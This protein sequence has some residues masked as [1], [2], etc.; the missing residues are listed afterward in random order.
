M[1]V[2]VL[3]TGASGYVGGRLLQLLSAR[4]FP[5]RCLAR[6]P[7]FLSDQITANVDVVRADLL[8]RDSLPWA[9]EGIDSA[10]YLVHSMGSDGDFEEMDRLAARNFAQAAANAGVRRIIYLGGLGDE[11]DRL[12]AHLR[13][14][15]EVGKVLRSTGVQVIEFRASIVLGAGSLSFEM[16]RALVEK[17]PVMITPKWVTVLAQP[18]AVDDLLA[19]LVAA[20]G[21]ITSESRIYEI[22]GADQVS[23]GG[24]M[25]EYARQR[26]LRRLQIPVPV[27]TP[28]LSSLWLGFVTPLYVRTGRKLIESVRHATIVRDQS[29]LVDFKIRPVGY[30]EA[31]AAALRNEN[32]EFAETRGPAAISASEALSNGGSARTSATPAPVFRP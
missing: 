7:E 22:G 18:I 24:L 17:L 1:E 29:A 26:G 5:V 28:W 2:K 4:S 11:Q 20:R 13:S 6:R 16:I 30:R 9:F 27:L 10:Y 31:I 12:S 19:Y 21:L 15:H 32:K 23:Y 25:R 14:R 3:L 8:E